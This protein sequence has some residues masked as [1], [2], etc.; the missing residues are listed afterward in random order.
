MQRQNAEQAAE[1]A[2]AELANAHA[3]R[4]MASLAAA[5]EA[6]QRPISTAT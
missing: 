5:R 6:Q 3:E 4:N 2:L 1:Q